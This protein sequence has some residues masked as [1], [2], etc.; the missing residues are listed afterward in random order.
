MHT[1][2]RHKDGR[3]SSRYL[4]TMKWMLDPES[5]QFF[6]IVDAKMHLYLLPIP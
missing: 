4:Q 1:K 6:F 2:M 3:Y 5:S